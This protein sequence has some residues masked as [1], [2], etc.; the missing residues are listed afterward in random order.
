MDFFETSSRMGMLFL[1]INFMV[2]TSL[3]QIGFL[4]QQKLMICFT[5]F[6][7]KKNTSLKNISFKQYFA[8]NLPL[9]TLICVL[10]DTW[11]NF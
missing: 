3:A 4:S 6:D 2:A 9:A 10:E 5:L 8:Y 11:V 7:E 1:K